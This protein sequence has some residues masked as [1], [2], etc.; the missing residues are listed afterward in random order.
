M[1]RLSFILSPCLVLM[2][3][4]LLTCCTK[5]KAAAPQQDNARTIEMFY[6][7]QENQ[8]GL[9]EIL[10][11]F[12]QDNP[13]IKIKTLINPNDG[14]TTMMTRAAQG[15]L[16]ALIQ[17]KG[18]SRVTEYAKRGY[19]LDITHVDVLKKIHPYAMPSVLYEKRFFGVPM[20]YT[21]IGILYNKAIFKQ[22]LL[23]PPTTFSELREVCNILRKHDITPFS[24][25]LKESWEIANFVSLLHTALLTH[26][27]GQKDAATMNE[28]YDN[29]ISD[30]SAGKVGYFSSDVINTKKLFDI[31]NFY[32]ENM[33]ADAGEMDGAS[34]E[35]LFLNEDAAMIIQGL[36]TYTD[37]AKLNPD[38]EV[39]FVPFPVF[40]NPSENKFYADVD[41]VFVVSSQADEQSQADAIV[42][43]NWLSTKKGQDLWVKKYRLAHLFTDGDFSAL[44][45]PYRVLMDSVQTKGVY[46]MLVSRYP[47]IVFDDALHYASQ[48]YMLNLTT[49]DNMIAEIEREWVIPDESKD[50]AAQ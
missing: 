33:N 41:S 39:G 49:A 15:K 32:K 24:G 23:Q 30:A 34:Q 19:L 20:D 4:L 5:Q 12:H 26:K 35:R 25:L 18:Y 17:M 10:D 48:K 28:F 8:S 27:F 50:T 43:L 37:I 29:F 40:D 45:E 36:W 6:Y 16:P 38:L 1:K 13:S 46:P 3:A 42:F 9:Q 14:D 7:K 47:T 44:G 22:L 2:L 21:G 11:A 31:L